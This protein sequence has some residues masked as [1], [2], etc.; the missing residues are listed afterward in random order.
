MTIIK[1]RERHF[2]DRFKCYDIERTVK[3]IY[4]WQVLGIIY[5][6]KNQF[7]TVAISTDD[8]IS[9]TEEN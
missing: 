9:I 7:E 2:I 4:T 5:G 1:Y 6:Y 3:L 8:I